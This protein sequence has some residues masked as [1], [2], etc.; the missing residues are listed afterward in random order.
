MEE[1]AFPY[2]SDGDETKAEHC[3]DCGKVLPEEGDPAVIYV[4]VTRRDGTV[5]VV[6]ACRRHWREVQES[7]VGRA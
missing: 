4:R 6:P 1:P 5:E 3:Y 7:A 2:Y